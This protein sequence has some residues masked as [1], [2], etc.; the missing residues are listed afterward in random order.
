MILMVHYFM[1]INEF[2]MC[3]QI[4]DEQFFTKGVIYKDLMKVQHRLINN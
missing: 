1:Q 4:K 2:K 3:L